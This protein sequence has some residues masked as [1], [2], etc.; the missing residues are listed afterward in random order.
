MRENRTKARDVVPS[1]IEETDCPNCGYSLLDHEILKEKDILEAEKE[2]Y[3]VVLCSATCT[4]EP[5]GIIL[6]VQ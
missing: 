6:W 1:C 5:V 2:G 4:N 3:K